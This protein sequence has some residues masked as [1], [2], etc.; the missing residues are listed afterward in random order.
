MQRCFAGLM[1][2]FFAVAGAARAE[3]AA[4]AISAVSGVSAGD[5]LNVRS[6]PSTEDPVIGGLPNGAAVEVT[7]RTGDG[8]ARILHG[9]GNGWVAMRYLQERR[10]EE[11]PETLF[12][13]GTEPF[14]SLTLESDG[15]MTF[16][17]MEGASSRMSPAW[18]HSVAGRSNGSF[19]IGSDSYIALFH[20]RDC[21]DGM[22]DRTY[23][24]AL[25]FLRTGGQG[26]YLQGCCRMLR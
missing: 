12:C 25:D 1:V 8:W 26:A 5:A 11:V 22:S 15:A 7:A 24:W 6:G 9:E 13:G 19:A 3:N 18:R 2:L 23:G 21:S 4:P 16:T 20:R 17:E 10:A 14:W